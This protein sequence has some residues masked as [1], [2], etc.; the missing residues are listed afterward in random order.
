MT[1]KFIKEN[2]AT[3]QT[4]ENYVH[5]H[6]NTLT[7]IDSTDIFQEILTEIN[8]LLEAIEQFKNNGSGWQ[9]NQVEHFDINTAPFEPVCG[10][11]YIPLPSKLASKR[12]IINVKN[13]K[14]HECFKWAATSAVF[15]I[16]VHPERLNDEMRQ[17]SNNFNWKGIEF[18]VSLMHI[19]KFENQNPFAV[20]VFGYKDNK[21]YHLRI[22]NK[23][24]VVIRLL[25]ISNE[26]TN[27]YCWIKNMSALLS[28]QINNYQHKRIFCDRYLNSFQ[29]EKSLESIL[30]TAAKT[31]QS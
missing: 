25:L 27:H 23:K 16:K 30:N 12:A 20:N 6:S 28:S 10:T 21:V 7:I 31:K 1:C 9:F 11:S 24:A 13:D 4:D 22:S 14:D 26:E 5:F 17:N 19:N 18:P 29:S 15:P 2:P 3:G 8:R